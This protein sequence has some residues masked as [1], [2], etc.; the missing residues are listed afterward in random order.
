MSRTHIFAIF[1][2]LSRYAR[3]V[4]FAKIDFEE[5]R[6]R[7]KYMKRNP[8]WENKLWGKVIWDK[9]TALGAKCLWFLC[10][11]FFYFFLQM[12]VRWNRST[13]SVK[14]EFK[15]LFLAVPAILFSKM[16]KAVQHRTLNFYAIMSGLKCRIYT[17]DSHCCLRWHLWIANSN[18]ISVFNR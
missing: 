14:W 15:R 8:N 7:N 5:I 10:L 4:N 3:R 1:G 13:F 11:N 6:S 9:H 17:A 2:K 12:S 18:G 16:E